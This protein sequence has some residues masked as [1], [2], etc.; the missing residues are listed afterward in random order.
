MV[1]PVGGR[2]LVSYALDTAMELSSDPPVLV[3]GSD[4]D[5]I[6]ATVGEAAVF[7]EQAEL[8]GT[9]HAV[10]QA[11]ETLLGQSGLVLVT[12]ADMPLLT[13]ETL[14][15][16]VE[17]QQANSGPVTILILRHDD[18]RGFG[19][20]IRAADGAV[21]QV[22]E[23]AVATQAQL[24]LRE[25]NA[26]V[27]CFDAAWL[28]DSV[29][30]IPLSLPKQE[31]YLT[32]LVGIAVD[33][34]RRVEAI[35]TEDADETIGIN[36]R[37]HLAEAE[38]A[39]QRRIAAELMLSGVTIV[40]PATTYI[41]AGVTVG[42]DT[43][44]WP[45]T[46]LRGATT[47]GED[48]QIGPSSII[49]SCR[50]GNGCRVVASVLEEAVMEDGADIGPFSHL[51]R[52]AW[53]C[54]GAHVGNFGELKNATLGPDAKMGHVSYLGDAE[55]GAG[56]NIAAGTITCNFDGVRKH[57]TVIG[58]GA[59]IGSDTMLVAPVRVG[60]DA[61]TGAGSVVTRDIPDGALAYGVPARVRSE[62]T[63]D[64]RD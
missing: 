60:K 14:R 34:G 51:R 18:P 39:L 42:Q 17:R 21:G 24:A 63:E 52:G 32:D 47:I 16:L 1:H 29:A 61:R 30:R 31:Y 62:G 2:P 38:G 28:W 7:V 11:R 26:G 46:F 22:V 35:V 9:G 59:F 53:L 64:G 43:V 12:Y 15:R 25:L 23:E 37:I 36:T 58:E 50:V 45:N 57:R 40:D 49:D 5:E 20:V 3:V 27:Y 8:K 19:R 56:A 6:R 55:V 33:Q 4:S 13:V 48:C 44:I 54:E 41:E 10:L